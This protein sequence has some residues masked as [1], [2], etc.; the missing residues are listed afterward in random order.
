MHSF[1][2]SHN[3]IVWMLKLRT[4]IARLPDY[5]AECKLTVVP[6]LAPQAGQDAGS[7]PAPRVVAHPP[8]DDDFDQPDTSDDDDL[9]TED[10]G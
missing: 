8:E 2:Q 9:A 4:D 10:R 5:V 6:Q 7:S 3:K 1:D